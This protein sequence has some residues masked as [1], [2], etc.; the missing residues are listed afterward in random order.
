MISRSILASLFLLGLVNVKSESVLDLGDKRELFV[1]HYLIETLNGLS[2]Q[3][4]EPVDKGSVLRFDKPWE[5]RF[6]A[7][8]TILKDQEVYR[9]YYR[10][11][12]S[13]GNDGNESEVTCYAESQ[14]GLQWEKPNLGLFEINGSTENN[15]VLA[16][17]APVTHNFCPFIDTNP[18]TKSEQRYKALGGIASSGL[19]AYTSPDGIHWHQ[20][21][22]QPVFK[23]KG[24][25]LDSQNVPF[26]SNTEKCY[27]LHFRS[28]VGGVRAIAKSTSKNFI[29]WTAPEQMIYSDTGSSTPSHHLYTN[30]T[31]PYFR[32]RHIYFSTAA[33][34]LPGRQ[35]L[36]DEQA[37]AINVHPKYFKDTSDS[38]FMTTR[39]T[40][41]YDR[42][43]LG[44]L[45]K[46]GIGAV[47]WVSRS[48]YPVLNLVQ[49]G[50]AEMSLYVNQNYGQPSAHLRRYAFRLDG[51]ACLAA[52][53]SG[54]TW[55]SKPF[56][57][58]GRH[59]SINFAT[60]A[61]GSIR[62]ELQDV[63]G[64]PLQGFKLEDAPELIGNEI[65]RQVFWN[66]DRELPQIPQP[67]RLHM[68][69]KDA[70]LYSLR[71]Q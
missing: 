32:A 14:D 2:L 39:G 54:G 29:D 59:L 65:E 22:S 36:S 1:D 63:N 17:A 45:I 51:I 5:G 6:S 28:S 64:T 8:G 7:Y 23:P 48:N 10:G 38:V 12:P 18:A 31:H 13:A 27:V 52:P 33:R 26:W 62:I 21:L 60:S 71:F 16:N 15:I 70:E 68:Q 53:F 46:P 57:F 25:V 37:R 66:S 34:F 3:L 44:A 4:K 55:T 40:Q 42:T 9:L 11:I 19:I 35:V 69:M 24:W 30:Q 43:F 41:T 58:T 67:V 50:S 61:A 47:N 20:L 56:S 49:T